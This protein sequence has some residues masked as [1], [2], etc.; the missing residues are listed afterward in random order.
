MQKVY[1][2]VPNLIDYVRIILTLASFYNMTRRPLLTVALYFTGGIILDVA[3]G[4]S[5]RYFDQCSKFGELLDVLLDRC[6]L[7]THSVDVSAKTRSQ[8]PWLVRIFFKE[9]I[10]TL[11]IVGQDVCVAMLY[12][13][14][15]SPGPM[16]SLGG[17][18][19]SL[20]M[21]LAQICSPFLIYR[22]VIVCFLLLLR[23]LGDLAELHHQQPRSDKKPK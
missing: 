6:A 20:W 3:D 11:V 12:L 18:A 4:V 22:Q 1:F 13:L 9:P 7:I 17:T 10:T 15:F 2:F 14:H 8:D 19:H 5:A 16:V 23:S 21:L